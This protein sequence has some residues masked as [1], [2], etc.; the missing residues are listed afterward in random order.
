MKRAAHTL[1]LQ[2]GH[3]T[4]QYGTTL[5]PQRSFAC[6]SPACEPLTFFNWSFSPIIAENQSRDKDNSSSPF[7]SSCLNSLSNHRNLHETRLLSN[8][9]SN[10]NYSYYEEPL[11]E[12]INSG[13]LKNNLPWMIHNQTIFHRPGGH[14]EVLKQKHFSSRFYNQG[15]ENHLGLSP[16]FGHIWSIKGTF[17]L[18]PRGSIVLN[19]VDPFAHP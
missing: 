18:G 2:A 12:W 14:I 8:D 1:V 15:Q 10:D 7:P 16:L 11:K 9:N 17:F 13:V 3:K 6:H 4:P 19:S 5:L